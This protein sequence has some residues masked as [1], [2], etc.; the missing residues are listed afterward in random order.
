MS[1]HATGRSQ[2]FRGGR[3]LTEAGQCNQKQ[4]RGAAKCPGIQ[5]LA[6]M[7]MGF[8]KSGRPDS[9]RRRPAW[10]AGILPLNY[11]RRNGEECKT[12]G[13]VGEEAVGIEAVSKQAVGKAAVCLDRLGSH[14]LG[15]YRPGSY[16]PGSYRR[17][18]YRPTGASRKLRRSGSLMAGSPGATLFSRPSRIHPS[19]S[20][21]SSKM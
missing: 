18:A 5:R 3:W 17:C 13:G 21:T 10:E 4:A 8:G 2:G 11:A 1:V 15:S 20:P 12:G 19:S 7:Q 6:R 16:R 9:N 14:R